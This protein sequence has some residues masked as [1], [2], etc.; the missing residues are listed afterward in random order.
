M[1]ATAAIVLAAFSVRTCTRDCP[2]PG[3]RQHSARTASPHRQRSLWPST[4]HA[5]DALPGL[6][7]ATAAH[8]T[9]AAQPFPTRRSPRAPGPAV[10]ARVPDHVRV[11]P[12]FLPPR[13]ELVELRNLVTVGE[14][15]L[16][17]ALQ[18]KESRGGHFCEDFPSAVPQVREPAV[19]WV[20]EWLCDCASSLQRCGPTIATVQPSQPSHITSQTQECRATVINTPVKRRLDLSKAATSANNGVTKLF[21]GSAVAPGSPKRG[22]GGARERDLLTTRSLVEE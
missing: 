22:G 21:G 10:I 6:A 8:L 2:M 18:R 20:F 4:S 12:S 3:F 9:R 17:S 1:R 15:I 14:L 5:G 16:S 19:G 7:C 13:A 11:S